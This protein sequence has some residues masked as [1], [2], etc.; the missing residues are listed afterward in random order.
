[1]PEL[2]HSSS[3]PAPARS[4]TCDLDPKR[5]VGGADDGDNV[6]E[7]GTYTIED[8]NKELE[9]ARKDIDIIFG[10]TRSDIDENG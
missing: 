3:D 2:L 5:V 6:S 1:M 10:I 9:Q 8:D 4:Q 7:S